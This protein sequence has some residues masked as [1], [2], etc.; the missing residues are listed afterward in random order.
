MSN[1][2]GIVG[3]IIDE[4]Y[5]IIKFIASGQFGAVFEAAE[6]IGEQYVSRCA[7][8]V[9]ASPDDAARNAL[10][11]EV[12]AL[13]QMRHPH[14][15]SYHHCGEIRGS[16]FMGHFYIVTELADG[17]LADLRENGHTPLD[18]V[19][20][21]ARDVA[22]ALAFIHSKK[23][24]HRDVKPKNIMRIG[25]RWKL[26]DFGLI[27]ALEQS[28]MTASGRKGTLGYLSPESLDAQVSSATDVWAL[29]VTIL[30]TLTGRFAYDGETE[31][32]FMKNLMTKEP[33]IPRGLPT[34]LDEV[35]RRCLTRDPR[36]RCSANWVC[37]HVDEWL[38][39][40]TRPAVNRSQDVRLP[41]PQPSPEAGSQRSKFC[42]QCGSALESNWIHCISC[43]ARRV[44]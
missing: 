13:G 19:C 32:A 29:G 42:I 16:S 44:M 9:I 5:H 25:S 31:A 12:R 1:L 14:V 43:G 34:P 11:R 22:S 27:R 7:I 33:T 28:M 30:E 35:V 39:S 36:E 40:R 15:L 18:Q 38:D 20:R 23:A 41:I 17:T 10:L 3:T 8:K 6:V 4:R 21:A 37:Q 24:V 26:G 2:G